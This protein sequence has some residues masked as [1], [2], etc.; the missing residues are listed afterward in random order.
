M[1]A[2][3]FDKSR[4]FDVITPIHVAFF[5]FP[6]P[7]MK[8][9]EKAKVIRIVRAELEAQYRRVAAAA[10]EAHGY[11]TDPDSKAESK[12]DTRS[13]EASY[14]AVGQ[15]EKADE[16]AAAIRSF[17]PEAFPPFSKDQAADLGAVVHVRYPDRSSAFFV[18][19]TRGGG[20]SCELEGSSIMV[21]TPSTP[22]FQA[23]EGGRSGDRVPDPGFEILSVL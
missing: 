10:R 5:S 2:K 4:Q 18:L 9:V 11:A 21:V 22:V 15:S 3:D 14:L 16:L 17:Q 8:A 23:L 6:T 19:A 12:Y 20:V 1:P 13:L 7:L